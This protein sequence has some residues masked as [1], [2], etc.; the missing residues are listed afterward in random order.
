MVGCALAYFPIEPCVNIKNFTVKKL[1][2]LSCG[3]L[4][5]FDWPTVLVLQKEIFLPS[6]NPGFN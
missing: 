1:F 6:I 4:I 3:D 2:G 5:N